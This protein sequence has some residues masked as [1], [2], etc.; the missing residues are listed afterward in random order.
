MSQEFE[1][2]SRSFA[3]S[4]RPHISSGRS[5]VASSRDS[6]D[7]SLLLRPA[8]TQQL[9]DLSAIS[10]GSCRPVAGLARLALSSRLNVCYYHQDLARAP[11]TALSL[12][13]RRA[14]SSL[15]I[16]P[17]LCLVL[18]RTILS[19]PAS[20][21]ISSL[22]N[23]VRTIPFCHRSFKVRAHSPQNA[24][25]FHDLLQILPAHRRLPCPCA[26]VA[27]PRPCKFVTTFTLTPAVPAFMLH[28]FS[29]PCPHNRTVHAGFEPT[30]RFAL[31]PTPDTNKCPGRQS[32]YE[33]FCMLTA[34]NLV[35]A[36]TSRSLSGHISSDLAYMNIRCRSTP[37]VDSR[38]YN[39]IGY[40]CR[41]VIL[42]PKIFVC[43]Y[44]CCRVVNMFQ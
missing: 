14:A 19:S 36:R 8:G 31:L 9:F 23:R 24:E 37:M 29:T 38:I 28:R 33:K 4:L 34:H 6:A 17:A 39:M 30:N 1:C 20:A 7:S 13:A 15:Q 16:L 21:R 12:R 25:T 41:I 40:Q 27:L 10:T 3:G 26:H 44:V 22:N 43:P 42:V 18:A 32:P 5:E 2:E 11:R 35:R